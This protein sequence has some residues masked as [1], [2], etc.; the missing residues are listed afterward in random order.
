MVSLKPDQCQFTF[1]DFEFRP[2]EGIEGNPIEVICM[3][4][5]DASSR[6]Y[7]RLWKDELYG[8]SKPPFP[9]EANTVLV[10]YFASAEM[11]CFEALGWEMPE[12]ILDL[13]A[14]F[15]NL[16]N[17]IF[18]PE[19]RSLLG[20]LKYFGLDAISTEHKDEMRDLALRGGKYS[21]AEK[22]ALLVY[23]QSD[24]DALYPL[25]EAMK[26]F[27]DLPHALLR[28]LYSTAL[29]RMES[30]GS[31]I[32]YPTYKGLCQHWE[33]IK[34]QLIA[35]VDHSYGVYQEGVFKEALFESYLKTRSIRWPRLDSGRL[36]LDEET[37]K[38]MAQLYP[39]LQPLRS[40]RDS[41]AKL[42]LNALQVGSDGRNRCLLSPFQSITGRNQPS[43]NKFVF[44]LSRWARGLIQPRQGYA[45]AYIDWSQQEF[46]IAAAL[47]GDGAMKE[48]YLSGDPYLTF[49]KKAGAVPIDA[50]K[51]SHPAERDQYKQCVLATQYGM[52][53][54]AL[55]ERIKQ[56]KLR[57]KQLL[58]MHRKVFKIF[59]DW[60]DNVYNITV[61]QNRLNTVFGWQMRVP[62]DINPRSLRNFPMQ[63]NA[64]EMLRIGC[65]LMVKRGIQLCAPV[66]DAV[67]IEAT[68]ETIEEQVAIAQEC[69]E[70][71]SLIVLEDF[72]LSSDA[73][74]IRYPGRF[75]EGDAEPF[76]NTVIAIY[77]RIKADSV[78]K[79][80]TNVLELLTPAQSNTS[81]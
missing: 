10:A 69:M 36:R 53:A 45:I 15:R 57:A 2:K 18:L 77:E 19:G 62:Q 33:G 17:G 61:N 13:Y 75:L 20:A 38:L 44:G 76:W 21:D 7:Y 71:A 55:A 46:G 50:T 73:K 52:G 59:W 78:E 28:G 11:S 27:L 31:P 70:Q 47:S 1:L 64:A 43:T 25:Y 12:N 65:I 40:L 37:F 22:E 63:A 42:R 79:L 54:E 30:L 41:L 66:H 4:A 56:P 51:Q 14:E 39:V 8:L 60:S 72:K 34:S 49:A 5:F 81:N 35:E 58:E 80:N 6:T 48:A 26:G 16:T 24:V 3:V 23:C 74:I 32:D 67:L 68:E 29:A 9:I